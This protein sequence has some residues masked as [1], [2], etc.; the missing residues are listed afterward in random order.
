M[1][2]AFLILDKPSGI[3]SRDAVDHAQRWFP[4]AKLGH[5]GTLDPLATG[6]LVLGIGGTATR[7]IE[8]IQQQEKMYRSTFILGAT[9]TTDDADG[10]VTAGEVPSVPDDDAV[11]SALQ[12]FVGTI[13]QT[14]PAYSAA[15]VQGQRAYT[16]ARRGEVIH[17]AP[18]PVLVHQIDLLRYEYPEI[19]V[20]L[21]CGKGTYIRSIARDLGIVLKT[22]GYVGR[23][24]RTRIGAF[25]VEDAVAWDASPTDA[26]AALHPLLTAVPT[27]PQFQLNEEELTRL[28]QGQVVR[29]ENETVHESGEVALLFNHK[30]VGIG[31][32]DPA[33]GQLRPTKMF[34]PESLV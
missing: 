14:P 27:L 17:L 1:A 16:K 34:P 12:Q 28:R 3:T 26:Q 18:R 31:H 4:K 9:S 8:Y 11:H 10:I 25:R 13:S 22:G 2:A 33:V 20:E 23:L 6:V 15:R 5:A 19:D 24:R 7:L 29:S 30:L 21:R 32:Y